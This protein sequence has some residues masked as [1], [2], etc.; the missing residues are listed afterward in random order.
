MEGNPYRTF[1]LSSCVPF[2]GTRLH[3]EMAEENGKEK[4]ENLQVSDGALLRNKLLK[5]RDYAV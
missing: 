3:R 1:Q 2:P 5:E 4:L